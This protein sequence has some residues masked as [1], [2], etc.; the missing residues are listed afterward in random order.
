MEM[1]QF[2]SDLSE[3]YFAWSELVARAAPELLEAISSL[4]L[5]S[6]APILGYLGDNAHRLQ[7]RNASFKPLCPFLTLGREAE[8]ALT[9][10]GVALLATVSVEKVLGQ[11]MLTLPSRD[12]PV[13]CG[14]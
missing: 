2:R 13:Q 7:R 4:T 3:A 10:D 1:R 5:R 9:A 6:R 11:L 8:P 12:H 14:A